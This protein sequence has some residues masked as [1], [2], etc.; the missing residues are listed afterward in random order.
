MTSVGYSVMSLATDKYWLIGK[1]KKDI[2][3]NLITSFPDEFSAFVAR[4]DY[5]DIYDDVI[6]IFICNV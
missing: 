5:L 6:V 1:N 4:K 3:W 2:A